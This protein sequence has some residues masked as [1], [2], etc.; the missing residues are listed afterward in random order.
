MA[1]STDFCP[2]LVTYTDFMNAANE[3]LVGWSITS[4][5]KGLCQFE[6]YALNFQLRTRVDQ[7]TDSHNF[8]LTKIIHAKDFNPILTSM[9]TFGT[10]IEQNIIN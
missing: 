8:W 6:F 5:E 3:K 10:I 4:S 1:T 9:T 2:F 7:L